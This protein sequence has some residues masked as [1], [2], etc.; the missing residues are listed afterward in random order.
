MIVYDGRAW[1]GKN[2]RLPADFGS[3]GSLGAGG[4][5]AHQDGRRETK[6][7]V[8]LQICIG[9][10]LLS[11]QTSGW[12]DDEESLEDRR[13]RA[14]LRT[15]MWSTRA[16]RNYGPPDGIQPESLIRARVA[17]IRLESRT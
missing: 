3:G 10:D 12:C 1:S 6:K 13:G 17:C 16:N 8:A 15:V 2:G 11:S 9:H 7:A 14:V 5:C 4:G